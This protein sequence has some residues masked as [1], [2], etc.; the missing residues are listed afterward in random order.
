[1]FKEVSAEFS[2]GEGA[3]AE[4][5]FQF[6]GEFCDGFPERRDKE[7]RVIAE[8]VI[9][10]RF[11]GDT[12]FPGTGEKE[13]RPA[14]FGKSDDAAE[15]G[16]AFFFGNAGEFREQVTASFGIGGVFA[17]IA[18]GVDTGFTAE[19]IDLDTRIVGNR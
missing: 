8:T 1:M 10:N 6:G 14:G 19:G 17:G 3:V 9:A 16:G 12:A 7:N 11:E 4:A 13:G 2:G 15:A 5:V 18:G